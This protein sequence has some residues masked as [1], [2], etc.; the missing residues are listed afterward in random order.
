MVSTRAGA[1]FDFYRCERCRRLCTALEMAHALELAGGGVCC[2]CG[3]KK[4]TPVNLPAYGWLL[5][6]VWRFL[7]VRVR[8]L[9][10]AGL[11]ENRRVEQL[12]RWLDT[13]TPERLVYYATREV[14]GNGTSTTGPRIAAPSEAVARLIV[15]HLASGIAGARLQ[16]AGL[17]KAPPSARPAA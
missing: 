7:V 6:R 14:L 4:Y 12:R 11:R 16:F 17:E 10:V 5:P 3:G 8:E 9:G 13:E 15:E 1:D 2:P